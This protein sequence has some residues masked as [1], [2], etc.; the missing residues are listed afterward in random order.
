[1]LVKYSNHREIFQSHGVEKVFQNLR[2]KL[3]LR[4]R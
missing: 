2:V 4:I 3:N 1:M